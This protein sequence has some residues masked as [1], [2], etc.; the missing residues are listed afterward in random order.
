MPQSHPPH[1]SHVSPQ[2]VGSSL[3]ESPPPSMDRDETWQR[4]PLAPRQIRPRHSWAS[5]AGAGATRQA[6]C[7]DEGGARRRF[8]SA[9]HTH[10]HVSSARRGH[11]QHLSF[12]RAEPP[13]WRQR[14][15]PGQ[16]HKLRPPTQARARARATAH[17]TRRR[18]EAGA[19]ALCDRCTA[20][21]GVEGERLPASPL[22]PADAALS[23][24]P[25]R[26]RPTSARLCER[27]IGGRHGEHAG[28]R[29]RAAPIERRL[30]R[31]P[32]L[33]WGGG[34]RRGI[35]SSSSSSSSYMTCGPGIIVVR[36]VMPFL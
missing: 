25:R 21:G 32:L 18:R 8:N 28:G 3:C 33:Q 26:W 5:S 11:A 13:S 14:S 30:G 29:W 7:R 35:P 2:A 10:T 16:T 1:Q 4:R 9:T 31:G 27:V 12:R 23:A 20:P 34:A 24:G 6:T 22:S 19:N 36:I 15:W 17:A